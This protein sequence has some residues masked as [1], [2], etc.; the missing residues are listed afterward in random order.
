MGIIH[1][2]KFE[3]TISQAIAYPAKQNL[4]K[5]VTIN[6]NFV[7]AQRLLCK[8]IYECGCYYFNA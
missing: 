7:F 8:M 4:W 5:K 1:E 6:K 2:S 3:N